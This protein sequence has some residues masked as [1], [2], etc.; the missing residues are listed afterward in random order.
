M[1]VVLRGSPPRDHTVSKHV[2]DVWRAYQRAEKKPRGV[3]PVMR[4]F[5][6]HRGVGRGE[7]REAE[8]GRGLGG[9]GYR[10][11]FEQH[12]FS[13]TDGFDGPLE[14]QPVR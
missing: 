9:V 6:Q 14:V 8:Q 4:G 10:R 12:V 13:G 7:L 5:E 2:H 11:L 1:D 3:E